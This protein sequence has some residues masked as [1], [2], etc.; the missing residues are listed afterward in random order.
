MLED[1]K[2]Y[3]KR[4][5]EQVEGDPMC[6]EYGFKLGSQVGLIEKDLQLAKEGLSYTDVREEHTPGRRNSQCQGPKAGTCQW[7]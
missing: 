5:N 3:G 6:G 7:L 2:C 1:G 4:E